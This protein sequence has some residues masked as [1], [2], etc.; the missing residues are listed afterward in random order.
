MS[1][2][3]I[4]NMVKVLFI[5]YCLVLIYI[6]LMPNSYRYRMS[7]RVIN[8]I[9]FH[10]IIDYLI[11]LSQHGIN[12]RFVIQNFSVNL[13]LFLP[14]GMSL[15]VIFKNKINNFWKFLITSSIIITAVEI[16]QFI[17]RIGSADIDD[18]ILNLIGACVGYFIVKL[19]VT[20]KILKLDE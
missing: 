10:T 18:V 7:S 11:R 5:I 8:I 12:T 3:K 17:T 13:I 14:M 2:K 4:I 16:I 9:P 1:N 15:P 20:R 6:L 19:K